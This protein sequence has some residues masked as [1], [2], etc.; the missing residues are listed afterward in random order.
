M[1]D[2]TESR[3]PLVQFA[4]FKAWETRV[5]LRLYERVGILRDLTCLGQNTMAQSLLL[6]SRDKS[7]TTKGSMD[8]ARVAELGRGDRVLD[9]H[10]DGKPER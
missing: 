2:E 3:G 7:V 5:V 8:R 6:Q 4:M 9:G 1:E 10:F